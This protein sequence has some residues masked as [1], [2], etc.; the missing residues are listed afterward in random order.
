M[1]KGISVRSSRQAPQQDEEAYSLALEFL[2]SQKGVTES[3]LKK[4]LRPKK[5]PKTIS[6]IYLGLLRSAINANMVRGVI[7]GGIGTVDNLGPLLC[8]FS[9]REALA[10]YATGSALLRDIERTLKPA[11]KIRKG[12]NCIWPKFCATILSGAQFLSAFRSAKD[13][14]SWVDAVTLFDTTGNAS[15]RII[16][17]NVQ[18]I[19]LALACDFLKNLGYVEFGKPDVHIRDIFLALR[20]SPSGKDEDLLA[21]IQ[22]VARNVGRDPYSVD[23]A[24]WLIGSGR[25]SPTVKIGNNKKAFFRFVKERSRLR[26]R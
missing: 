17:E 14:Y 20:L 23:A 5:R 6:G 21:A 2:R 18:G 16:S 12:K 24:F 7:K 22:R 19:G 4:S 3:L 9:P 26:S 25:L 13:F 15:A 11:G 8:E 1:A 10:R